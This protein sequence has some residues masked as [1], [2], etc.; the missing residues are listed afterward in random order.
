MYSFIWNTKYVNKSVYYESEKETLGKFYQ[1]QE[2]SNKTLI[3]TNKRKPEGH[4]N[5][6]TQTHGSISLQ[7][8]AELPK[9]CRKLNPLVPP[10]VN[11]VP[12]IESIPGIPG[13]GSSRKSI[14]ILMSDS[15]WAKTAGSCK[16]IPSEAKPLNPLQTAT[17]S[18]PANMDRRVSARHLEDTHTELGN[19][20]TLPV[21]PWSLQCYLNSPSWKSPASQTTKCREYKIPKEVTTESGLKYNIA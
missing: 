2:T 20:G 12:A 19:I 15:R 5:T 8:K 18:S 13:R 3:T 4:R 6:R 17:T 11:G 16:R 9:P 21:P 10:K 14:T 1:K 7:Q